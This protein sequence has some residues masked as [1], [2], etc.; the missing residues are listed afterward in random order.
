MFFSRFFF[1]IS[2]LFF[3]FSFFNTLASNLSFPLS[4][5]LSSFS[6]LPLSLI[7]FLIIINS[8]A[9]KI[10]T[11][12]F[13]LVY[14]VNFNGQVLASKEILVSKRHY[15][16]ILR[17]IVI[18]T[19]FFFFFFFFFFLLFIIYL[20]FVSFLC[21]V[22]FSFGLVYKVNF[23]GQVLAS[24][25]ILVSKRH[26][27]RILRDIVILTFFF[28]FFFL[29]FIIIIICLFV[30]CSSLLVLYIK[31]ILMAKFKLRRKFLFQKTS[32]KKEFILKILFFYF[33]FI[34]IFFNFL[35]FL[36]SDK[37]LF[38][39]KMKN[40]FIIDFLGYTL[41]DNRGLFSFSFSFSFSFFLS[42][43][44]LIFLLSL[45]FPI[46]FFPLFFSSLS[47][48]SPFSLSSLSFSSSPSP[49]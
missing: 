9:K 6:L 43:L 8:A 12:S 19:F 46:F 18:L 2:F 15:K 36:F 1:F 28:F 22:F 20:L 11:G 44:L 5:S 32:H 25:E 33:I 24:K 35:F 29:L 13:G 21:L 26:Y 40:P 49:I 48:L 27:K 30:L 39:R 7:F 45:F 3:S 38:D 37:F 14:K 16:R 17:E 41:M 23:N 4:L 42:L 47:L 34:F 31:L 10:G